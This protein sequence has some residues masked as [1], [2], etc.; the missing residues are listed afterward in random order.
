MS[1]KEPIKITVKHIDTGEEK[2][3]VWDGELLEAATEYKKRVQD[4]AD[5]ANAI[6]DSWDEIS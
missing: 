2:I 5:S 6:M 3:W 4:W 1:H